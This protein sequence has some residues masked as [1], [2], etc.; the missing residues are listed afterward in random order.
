MTSKLLSETITKSYIHDDGFYY[1]T[2]EREENGA[3]IFS[4]HLNGGFGEKISSTELLALGKIYEFDANGEL[5]F[6]R[7]E[8][9]AAEAIMACENVVG[10]MYRKNCRIITRST[11]DSGDCYF[12]V[13]EN[14]DDPCFPLYSSLF[15]ELEKVFR[16]ERSGEFSTKPEIDWVE[17]YFKNKDLLERIKQWLTQD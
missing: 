8:T 3:S 15:E 11:E 14:G 13:A 10:L 12:I 17:F 4:F 9:S 2:M 16:I 7:V 6:S 1:T 5:H